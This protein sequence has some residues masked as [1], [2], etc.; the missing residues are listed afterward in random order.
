M[1]VWASQGQSYFTVCWVHINTPV[2]RVVTYRIW[3]Y[4][5]AIIFKALLRNL[6]EATERLL[7]GL[8]GV[9][10]DKI[11]T[12]VQGCRKVEVLYVNK[13]N[14]PAW[15]S[16]E[17]ARNR[18]EFSHTHSPSEAWNWSLTVY[19]KLS[20]YERNAISMLTVLRAN[21]SYDGNFASQLPRAINQTQ[22]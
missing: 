14:S 3:M 9:P 12:R 10:T 19:H 4:L 18:K 15:E 5:E 11:K 8:F 22:E 2:A 6:N 21:V 7:R 16:Q 17:M 1:W 13:V 20:R